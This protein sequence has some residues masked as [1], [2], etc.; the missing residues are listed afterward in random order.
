MCG[1]AAYC[2]AYPEA[3]EDIPTL[4][5]FRDWVTSQAAGG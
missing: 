3:A 1:E 5:A 2:L 4:R